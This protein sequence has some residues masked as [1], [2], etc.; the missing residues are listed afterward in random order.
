[1]K[2]KKDMKKGEKLVLVGS[3]LICIT[4]LAGT[5]FM[6]SKGTIKAWG[7]LGI[8]V[9]LWSATFFYYWRLLQ[10][11]IYWFEQILDHMPSPI[12]VTDM[13]MNWTFINK[14]VEEFLKLKRGSVMGKHCSNWGAQIC[15]T[16]KCGVHCLRK[17]QPKTSFN[18]QGGNFEV[19]SNY[20]Y[21]LNGKKIGHIEV[22]NETT[23]KIKLNEIVA[24]VKTEVMD[25][26]IKMTEANSTQASSIQEIS[27]SIEEMTATIQQNAE[28][29]KHTEEKARKVSRDAELSSTSVK[30]SLDLIRSI[31]ERISLIQD[32]AFQTNLL[33][34]NA[35]VEAARAGEQGKGFAVVA[36]EVRKL[37]DH[38][39]EAANEIVDMSVKGLQKAE[40]A[41]K[42]LENVIPEIK[43]TVELISEINSATQE[44][45][46][47]AMQISDS[48]QNV[49]SAIQQTANMSL[50]MENVI[51]RLDFEFNMNKVGAEV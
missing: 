44:Q 6:V 28:N 25:M 17:G 40:E 41:Y 39:K 24:K 47:G 22:V 45:S 36:T 26:A 11:K 13:N 34:L 49:N 10:Q 42:N 50:N 16:E 37:A 27:S 7:A 14:P 32:I 4:I 9:V 8:N 3:F 12:S 20:L 33:A 2:N 29:S 18:Q 30:E 23:E 31:S 35:A 1:M 43:E 5:M 48:S 38:S 51:K 19:N 15:N 46:S 21:S